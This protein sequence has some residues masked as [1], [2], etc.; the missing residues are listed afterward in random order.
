MPA[1]DG[2]AQARGTKGAL[3]IGDRRRG[4]T[5]HVP[6]GPGTRRRAPMYPPVARLARSPGSGRSSG[7]PRGWGRT[8]SRRPSRASGGDPRTLPPPAQHPPWPRFAS[9]RPE[10]F[11][12]GGEQG[13]PPSDEA[14]LRGRPS[15]SSRIRRRVLDVALGRAPTAS[16]SRR[17]GQAPRRE[18]P[19][20]G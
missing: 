16:G 7:P 10:T 20:L 15:A 13:L 3:V 2:L 19:L 9:L 17:R 12:A 11:L 1:A 8:E 4:G 18:A 6:T 14:P 5:S